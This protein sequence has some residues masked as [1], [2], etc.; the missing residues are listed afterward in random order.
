MVCVPIFLL[1]SG[2]I[3]SYSIQHEDPV[4]AGPDAALVCRYNWSVDE[5]YFRSDNIFSYQWASASSFGHH[6]LAAVLS[7]FTSACPASDSADRPDA[8]ISAHALRHV[9]KYT[10]GAMALPTLFAWGYTLGFM[11]IPMT[12]YFAVCLEITSLDGPR[13]VGL[14][15]GQLD[16]FVNVWGSSN[17]RQ[18]QGKD[19]QRQKLD[20]AIREV[21]VQAWRK[22]WVPPQDGSQVIIA[23][24]DEL[25]AIAKGSPTRNGTALPPS[26]HTEPPVQAH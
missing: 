14:A 25:D 23:C 22:A 2:C 3:A 24:R 26:E 17:H 19:E 6:D 20:Q 13:R 10:R 7:D 5:P 18:Y 8:R 4:E 9:N 15:Q 21:A 1:L 12:D 16:R 11:P